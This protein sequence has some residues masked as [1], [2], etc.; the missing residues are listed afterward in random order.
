MGH[1]LSWQ[2][3]NGENILLGIDPIVGASYPGTLPSGLL[4][5]LDDMEINTL[6]C[7]RNTLVG[8]PH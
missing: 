7:A 8:S 4:D 1:D 2:I 5:F 3:G 6:A